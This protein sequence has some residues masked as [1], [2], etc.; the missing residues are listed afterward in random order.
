M[1]LNNNEMAVEMSIA[2]YNKPYYEPTRFNTGKIVPYITKDQYQYPDELLRLFEGSPLHASIVR[3]KASYISGK[4]FYSEDNSTMEFINSL[5]GN[6]DISDMLADIAKDLVLYDGFAVLVK[7]S[8]DWT[9][10]VGV[11]YVD[12]SKVRCPKMDEMGDITKYLYSNV[13]SRGTRNYREFEAFNPKV[14]GI[15]AKNYTKAKAE[16][17][18][19]GLSE[20]T[21]TSREQL[22]YYTVRNSS[23]LYYPIPDYVAG[24]HDIATDMDICRHNANSL[25][26]NLSATSMISIIGNPAD[27]TENMETQRRFLRNY[28]GA[29]NAG[30]PV[31]NVIENKDA[32]P[33]VQSLSDTKGADKM[34]A[35]KEQVQENILFAH[36]ITS[37]M[38]VGIKTPGQLGGSD[39]IANAFNLFYNNVIREKQ[40][41][42]EGVFNKLLKVNGLGTVKIVKSN[43][44]EGDDTS[45]DNETV[46]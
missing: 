24:I 20:V 7:W 6:A 4:G 22:L 25:R 30:R 26:N 29:M 40:A 44:F 5:G 32:A 1:E 3:S 12:F 9:R 41:K 2:K 39:E 43:P 27:S 38:L 42:I 16:G 31:L 34:K 17:D 10:V 46:D 15:R 19:E 23:N 11:R 45:K 35:L 13:W 37:P 21:S 33:I 18:F 14:A 36:R 8:T 28:T